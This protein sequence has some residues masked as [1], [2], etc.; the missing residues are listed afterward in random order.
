MAD[1]FFLTNTQR[2]FILFRKF[3]P[4]RSFSSKGQRRFEFK[5]PILSYHRSHQPVVGL[6]VKCGCAPILLYLGTVHALGSCLESGDLLVCGGP[7]M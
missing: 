2:V 3:V 4:W 7:G 6:H 1:F 5:V